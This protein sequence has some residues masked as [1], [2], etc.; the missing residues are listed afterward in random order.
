MAIATI[1]R[2]LGGA[3]LCACFALAA[4]ALL[5]AGTNAKG[6][7]GHG[8]LPPGLAKKMHQDHDGRAERDMPPGQ[9]KKYGYRYYPEQRVFYSPERGLWFW[10]DAGSWRMGAK[11]PAGIRLATDFV[12]LSLGAAEPGR[13]YQQVAKAH[14]RRGHGPPP[15][16]PAHGRRAFRYR[17]YPAQRVYYAPD[18][19]M[20]FWLSAGK[21]R[22]GAKLPSRFSV[23]DDYVSLTMGV[24]A[25]YRW[26]S[27]VILRFGR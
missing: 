5:P 6:P 1:M 13:Y 27:E 15:W 23:G 12:S 24:E 14:P 18:R 21:W 16:A 22:M 20:W 4:L 25:P 3:C 8:G 2:R 10:L 11:L 7:P 26:D 19:G 17:Y 9:A